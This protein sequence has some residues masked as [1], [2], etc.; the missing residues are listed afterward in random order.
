[1]NLMDDILASNYSPNFKVGFEERVMERLRKNISDLQKSIDYA[2]PKVFYTGLAVAA[3]LA[4]FM[5]V[6]GQTLSIDSLLGIENLNMEKVL[7]MTISNY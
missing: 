3:A 2:F 1:M 4:I 5:L 6:T 7:A